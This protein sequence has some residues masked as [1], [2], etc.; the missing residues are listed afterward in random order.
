MESSTWACET[1]Y[2]SIDRTALSKS[3]KPWHPSLK[4]LLQNVP[5]EWHPDNHNRYNHGT[6]FFYF[7]VDFGLL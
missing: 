2:A 3:P 6:P 1:E 7:C 4:H 5:A